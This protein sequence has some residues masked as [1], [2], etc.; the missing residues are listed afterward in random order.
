MV[1]EVSSV[2]QETADEA[3]NVSAAAEE[4]AASLS[5]AAQSLQELTSLADELN[6]QTETFKLGTTSGRSQS[7]T[8]G[9]QSAV[10][11]DGGT[12]SGHDREDDQ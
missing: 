5:E 4:Q 6:D 2:S 1:D 11:N 10:V 12:V 8:T 3:S 9:S 7:A